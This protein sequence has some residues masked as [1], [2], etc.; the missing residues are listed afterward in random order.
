MELSVEWLGLLFL[1]AL[2]AGFID[3]LAGGGGLL[4]IPMLLLAQVPPLSALATN[5]VQAVSGTMTATLTLWRKGHLPL[6]QLRSALLA[7]FIG[8]SLGTLAVHWINVQWLDWLIPVVLLG[9]GCYF[10]FSPP[11]GE[12]APQ[13]S[14]RR[15]VAAVVPAIG[16]YD[17]VL[18]PGTGSFFAL[19][20]VR[21]RGLSLVQATAQAKGLNAASNAASVF[22]F[23]LGGKV[24]WLV[25][26][27]MMLGQVLGAYF[28]SLVMV[29]QGHRFIRP[30]VVLM[31]FLMVGRYFYARLLS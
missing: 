24:L 2:L 8:A 30:L 12:Q 14:Q 25:A 26:V 3:T 31:C 18:G 11:L 1:V 10:L 19:A 9:I 29:R 17:G 6:R 16:F 21:C 5:K 7:S 23:I 15:Y 27:V 22:I 13:I 20:G 4:T 28:G